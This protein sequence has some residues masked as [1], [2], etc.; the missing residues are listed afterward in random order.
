MSTVFSRKKQNVQELT[1]RREREWEERF[2]NGNLLTRFESSRQGCLFIRS[3]SMLRAASPP[4]EASTACFPFLDLFTELQ[5]AVTAYLDRPSL[6]T[7]PSRAARSR[8]ASATASIE[9]R[10]SSTTLQSS[11]MRPCT[12]TACAEAAIRR[13][14]ARKAPGARRF[15]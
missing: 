9:A 4:R 8:S 3:S 13:A 15:D 6:F 7:S 11:A 2:H 1:G 14:A 10:S 12:S 5:G